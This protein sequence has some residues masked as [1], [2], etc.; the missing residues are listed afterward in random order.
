M[1]F[2]SGIFVTILAIL[3]LLKQWIVKSKAGKVTA[4]VALLAI[5]GVGYMHQSM[6]TT[7]VADEFKTAAFKDAISQKA[8]AR[9]E[10]EKKDVAAKVAAVGDAT[11]H[12]YSVTVDKKAFRVSLL[13]NG[14]TVKEYVCAVGRNPGQKTE[15][16]DMKTPEGTFAVSGIE[17][18]SDWVT[19][20]GKRGTYGKWFIR[21]DTDELSQG[22]WSGIGITGTDVPA[23]LGKR[24]TG[25]SI[26]M[27]NS[28]VEDLKQYIKEGTKVTIK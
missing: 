15:T 1:K 17:A 9:Q 3:V 11:S 2:I 6:A 7:P 13:D 20:E 22:T 14:K 16:G 25:G 28:D 24:S 19:A 23:A 21:L 18:S 8:V 10:S 5:F 12:N 26:R 27:E 4:A